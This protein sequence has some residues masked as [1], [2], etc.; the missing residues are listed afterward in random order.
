MDKGHGTGLNASARNPQSGT[1]GTTRHDI[2]H[3]FYWVSSAEAGFKNRHNMPLRYRTSTLNQLIAYIL[4][5][6]KTGVELPSTKI[7]SVQ[8]T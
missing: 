7:I 8:K 1:F 6:C 5:C 3:Y 2:P 4:S